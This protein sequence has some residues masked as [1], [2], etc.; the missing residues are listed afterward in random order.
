MNF[1]LAARPLTPTDDRRLVEQAVI[2]RILD[3]FGPEMYVGFCFNRPDG[4]ANM[5]NAWTGGGEPLG[6]QVDSLAPAAGLDAADWLHI[7]D[8]HS[9][10]T[11]RGRIRVEAYPLRPILADVQAGERAPEERRAGLRRLLDCAA[12]RTG[13]TCPPGLPRW[14]GFGPALLNRK[15]R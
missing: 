11:H 6:D 15:A 14:P 1:A 3:E 10:V 5:W 4:G 7:G 2:A 8:R 9:T 12:N 13:Q